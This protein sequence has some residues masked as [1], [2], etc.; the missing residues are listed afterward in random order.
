M[1]PAELEL[2][3]TESCL[4]ENN[5]V[6][7]RL[8]VQLK[9]LGV[10]LAIDDFGTGYS[11]MAYLR[12][13]SIDVL[14]ID[15]SFLA[16]LGEDPVAEAILR[17]MVDLAHALNLE[18]VAEGIETRVQ[19]DIATERQCEYAQGFKLGRPMAASEAVAVMSARQR[20]SNIHLLRP[21]T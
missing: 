18:I 17:N 20:E 14:K 10:R 21:S 4:M 6:T 12:D 2:E 15:R 19:L 16:A 11:S 9:N 7:Q 8:L 13:F 1:L 3:L 5:Q